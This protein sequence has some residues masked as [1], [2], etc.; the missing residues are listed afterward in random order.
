MGSHWSGFRRETRQPTILIAV[1]LSGR[2]L[3]R[4]VQQRARAGT[5]R[6]WGDGERCVLASFLPRMEARPVS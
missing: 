4:Q 1:L 5:R 2:D 3:Y 6:P